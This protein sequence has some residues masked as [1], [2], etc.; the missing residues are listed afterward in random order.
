MTA[1]A[2]HQRC[3]HENGAIEGL[4]GH[5]KRA[6]CRTRL[7]IAWVAAASR[8]LT[9]YRRFIDEVVGRIYNRANAKRI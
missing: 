2:Q 1:I 5:L 6:D 4:T 8:D 7:I 3:G 9:A